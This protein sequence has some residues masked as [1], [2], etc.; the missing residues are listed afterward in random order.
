MVQKKYKNE[1]I[2]KSIKLISF[3]YYIISIKIV[4]YSHLLDTE[5]YLLC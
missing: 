3:K 4:F 1:M 5:S 2:F